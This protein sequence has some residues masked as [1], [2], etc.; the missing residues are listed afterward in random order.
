M[1]RQRP[2][3]R[4]AG[5]DR[6]NLLITPGDTDFGDDQHHRAA[7]S[8]PSASR[9]TTTA[10]S[11]RGFITPDVNVGAR[12]AD[13]TGVVN[14]DF[15]N[16]QVVATQAYTVAQASTLVKETRHAHRRRRPLLVASYN[17][18]N[19]D[20]NDGAARF[21]TIAD[22][23][24]NKLQAPDI[25]ACRKSRTTTARPDSRRR[26]RPTSDAADA[27]RRDQRRRAA[28]AWSTPSSTI[29]SSATTP[30]AAS[31]AAIS[32]P[33]SSTAP[34]GSTSSTA[35]CARSPPTARLIRRRPAA[36][37]TSRPIPTIRSS[38]SR[39]P[40]VATFSFNGE[41]VTIVN[42]HF[43]SKG[44]SAPLFGSD[45]PP[46]NAGEVQRA[47]QAQAVNNFVD[48]LLAPECERQ[49]DRRR[50]PERVPA[51]RAD[52]GAARHRHDLQLRRARQR[53]VRCDRRLHARRHGGPAR[54][55]RTAAGGRAV[56]LRVRGQL[57]RRSITS[58]S[59]T[60]C[61]AGAEFDVVRIN[62]EFADQTSDHDPLVA[63]FEIRCRAR[64]H[65][66]AAD[67]ACVGLRG[68]SRGDRRCAALRGDRRPARR[69]RD[70]LDHARVRR[71]LHS[72]PVLQ[73]QQRSGARSVLRGEHRPRRHPHPE[74][75]RDRGLGHRQPR[76]RRR[77]AR[78]AEPH[79]SGRGRPDGG[80]A[81]EGTQFAYLA[82][83][84]NFA[85]EPDLQPE[86]HHQP[87]DRSD[88]R[89]RCERGPAPRPSTIID[90]N[91]EQIGVVGVTT[92]VFESITTPGGVRIIG[93][94]T[95]DE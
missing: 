24:L 62:A 16:Y 60:A 12:L 13:V 37:P 40:L 51:R 31:P 70:E 27:G 72:E 47:A 34:T 9:S 4:P 78:G 74:H 1:P 81:Y 25:V 6:G 38:T 26:R 59:P 33:P 91:G 80:G 3:P 5:S 20:P 95:L 36:T 28:P 22:E 73:R 79:P 46:F 45:Q 56:R 8:I 7:T 58:W 85:G 41:D 17:A 69:P 48:T 50:R 88:L 67:P 44:G 18:E 49:G 86:R 42:N 82:A 21:N 53:S 77:A 75:D 84:L 93:P 57:R 43:T 61:T 83:N 90:E 64:R 52:A 76:V 19:L 65:L 55:P 63:S 30:T 14:Y 23:I 92:P 11:C 32:A 87:D 94:R 68:R 10:A 29:R 66:Q 54:S 89:H 15:G 39:P 2:R 35:R 71:Q